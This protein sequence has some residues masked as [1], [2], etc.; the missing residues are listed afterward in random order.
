MFDLDEQAVYII[1]RWTNRGGRVI[2]NPVMGMANGSE[3]WT[4]R[5]WVGGL[6]LEVNSW[7]GLRIEDSPRT[8]Q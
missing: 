8:C 6:E 4:E 1:S 5:F 2:A 3:H 7:S